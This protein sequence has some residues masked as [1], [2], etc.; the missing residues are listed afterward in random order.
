MKKILRGGLSLVFLT[1]LNS[2]SQDKIS[3]W[4]GVYQK[5]QA[6][7]GEAV[8]REEC[9]DCHG[10]D[11]KGRDMSPSLIGIGFSFKWEGKTLQ[12]FYSSMR[13][14]MPQTA[15]GS[16]SD[17]NYVSLTSFLLSENGFPSGGVELTG[18]EAMLESIQITSNR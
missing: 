13:L 6:V 10:A 12:E 2:F 9:S 1:A 14:G 4:S 11:L 17:S 15:P 8:Y 5:D 16:L 3:I 18:D 7:R